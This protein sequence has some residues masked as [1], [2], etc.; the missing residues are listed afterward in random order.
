MG[1]VYFK[2]KVPYPY[3]VIYS[4]DVLKKKTKVLDISNTNKKCFVQIN[5][6]SS[7]QETWINICFL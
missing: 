2:K 1:S 7:P 5:I 3:L 6:E 4:P